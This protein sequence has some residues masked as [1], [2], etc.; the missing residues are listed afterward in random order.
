MILYDTVW[1]Y[2][3][4]YDTIWYYMMLYDTILYYMI[5]YDTIW[6]YMIIIIFLLLLLLKSLLSRVTTDVQLYKCQ[7]PIWYYVILYFPVENYPVLYWCIL[8]MELLP[9]IPQIQRA[10]AC[11]RFPWGLFKVNREIERV[12]GIKMISRLP[13]L[14]G[15]F[16]HRSACCSGHSGRSKT[17]AVKRANI[18]LFHVWC[19]ADW[20]E[21]AKCADIAGFLKMKN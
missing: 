18:C 21:R 5:L 13:W 10:R 17:R 20:R 4:L 8:D 7:I 12:S 16:C 6:Y 2:M 14:R 1:Y 19:T 9:K 15:I 3:I 11:A